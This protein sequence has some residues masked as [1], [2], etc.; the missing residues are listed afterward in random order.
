MK[1]GSETYMIFHTFFI[2]IT[3]QPNLSKKMANIPTWPGSS[4]FD[5]GLTPFSFYDS[6]LLI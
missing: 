2:F 6:D 3:E 1:K 4:S 5:A